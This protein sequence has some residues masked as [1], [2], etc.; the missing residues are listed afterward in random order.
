MFKP[1][2]MLC[3]ACN[4]APFSPPEDFHLEFQLT[5]TEYNNTYGSHTN[6]PNFR[7]ASHLKEILLKH[8]P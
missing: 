2:S 5:T 4:V 3:H 6:I 8:S 1:F 7:C